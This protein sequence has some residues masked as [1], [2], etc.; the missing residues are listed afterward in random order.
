MGAKN[1]LRA[2]FAGVVGTAVMTAFTYLAPMM[3]MPPMNIPMMLSSFL[4]V[5]IFLGWIMHFSIGSM[6]AIIY[7]FV[8]NYLP[9]I[10]W[11]NGAIYGIFPWLV[12]QIVVMPMM[13]MGLFSGSFVM[14]M[15]SFVGHLIYGGT[16]GFVYASCCQ[17]SSSAK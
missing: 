6:L 10:G 15:G 13:G 9:S 7:S 2:L 17:R 12:A 8:C 4:G 14:A 5:S 3:G 1:L 11:K 16:V